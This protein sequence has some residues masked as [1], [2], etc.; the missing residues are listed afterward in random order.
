MASELKEPKK[1]SQNFLGQEK[2]SLFLWNP[3]VKIFTSWRV[4]ILI[5]FLLAS[6]VAIS[7]KFGETGLEISD[8]RHN[9]SAQINGLPA[10]TEL[11]AINGQA[12][13]SQQEFQ[14]KMPL[15]KDGDLVHVETDKGTF[16]FKAGTFENATDLGFTVKKI[17]KSNLQQGLDLVGGVRV[18]LKP[19]E[20]LTQQQ[21]ADVVDITTKRLNVFGLKEINVKQVSDLEGN[22]FLLVEMAGTTKGEAVNLISQQGKFESKIGNES[23]FGG[24]DIK[25]VSRSSQE[26][27]GIQTCNEAQGSGWLCRFSFPVTISIESA[28]RHAAITGALDTQL[29]GNEQYLSKKLDLYLD[30]ELTDSLYI[31]ASLKGLE[32]TTFTIQGSGAG[33]SKQE[34]FNDALANMK[35]LQTIL[36]T[37][38]LPVKLEIVKTDI[39]SPALGKEFLR[40]TIIALI[41]A[42]IAVGV[43]LAVRYR[44]AVIAV[45]IMLT[46]LSEIIIIFGIAALIKQSIDLA[47]IAGILATVGTGVDAQ[48]VITDEVLAS[49]QQAAYNWKEKLKRSFFIIMGSYSTVIAAMIP[50]LLIGAGLLKG[51]AIVTIIGATIGV[52]VTR[53]AYA[54]I[55]EVLLNR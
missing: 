22:H 44:R 41:F 43:I 35:K 33:N 24:P 50:L 49:G 55:I 48:L 38:S 28:K 4:I 8:V 32:T 13:T 27:A 6:Y 2:A 30:S 45:P 51:F 31:S 46:S 14:S 26:G 1:I 17:P 7:P 12:I 54:R 36:I 20:Q 47:A 10:G 42:V 11:L 40:T 19:G 37:G 5:L 29:V 34:A 25:Q 21:F 9:S 18:L 52:F 3:A 23:V 16:V 53:P 39:I 15:I